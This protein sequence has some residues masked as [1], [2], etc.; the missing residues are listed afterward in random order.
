MCARSKGFTLIEIVVL[1][2]VVAAAL[3]GVLLVFQ[4]TVRQRRSAGAQAG[5]GNRR[6]DAG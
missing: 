5:A 4:N 3:V 6:G 1:I 2:V